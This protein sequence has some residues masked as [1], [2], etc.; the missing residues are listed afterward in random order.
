MFFP[1]SGNSNRNT[2]IAPVFLFSIFSIYNKNECKEDDCKTTLIVMI[3]IG[4][5]ISVKIERDSIDSLETLLL[6]I[7]INQA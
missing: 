6:I 4:D 3:H 1:K 5:V 7:N 2:F